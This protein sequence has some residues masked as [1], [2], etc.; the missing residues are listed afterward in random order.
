MKKCS[1]CNK[2]YDDTK[3]FCPV[4]GGQLTSVMNTSPKPSS[5]PSWFENWGG[6]LLTLIGL[7]V[8]WE[9]HAILGFVL[10]VIGIIS[11]W[12]SPNK[13]NKILSVIVGAITVLLFIIY[14]LI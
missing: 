13:I 10:A 4:C 3:M 6:V 9:V 1:T 7:V 12:S 11:G 2:E 8:A 14:V 5:S